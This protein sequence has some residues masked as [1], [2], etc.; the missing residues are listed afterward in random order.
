MSDC[1]I[2]QPK[3]IPAPVAMGANVETKSGLKNCGTCT[4][5]NM[6]TEKCREVEMLKELQNLK[7]CD[8]D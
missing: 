2:Y 7:G 3:N 4:N 1:P 8:A 5:W 6:V